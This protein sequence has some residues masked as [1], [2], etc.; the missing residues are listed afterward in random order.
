MFRVASLK[1]IWTIRVMYWMGYHKPIRAQQI[2]EDKL[3]NALCCFLLN[4]F[5]V[6]IIKHME[7]KKLRPASELFLRLTEERI[8]RGSRGRWRTRRRWPW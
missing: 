1:G 4:Y 8:R 2:G 3:E 5:V 7:E 6:K